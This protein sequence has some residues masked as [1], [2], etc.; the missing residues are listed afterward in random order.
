MHRL[1]TYMLIANSL[2]N[3]LS[4]CVVIILNTVS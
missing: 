1:H 4:N 3:F 2:L